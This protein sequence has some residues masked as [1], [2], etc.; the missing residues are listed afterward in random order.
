MQIQ[1]FSIEMDG[2][3]NSMDELNV[4]LRTHLDTESHR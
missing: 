3:G 4:F 1:V 2:D